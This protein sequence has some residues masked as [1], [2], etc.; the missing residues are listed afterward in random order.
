MGGG[1]ASILFRLLGVLARWRGYAEVP[2][3]EGGEFPDRIANPE[4][5]P[6]QNLSGFVAPLK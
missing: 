5:Y 1:L 2:G 6:T 3:G 4:A